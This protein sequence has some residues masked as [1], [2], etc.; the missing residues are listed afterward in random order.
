LQVAVRNVSGCVGMCRN[1]SQCVVR[2]KRPEATNLQLLDRTL[3][4]NHNVFIFRKSFT[5]AT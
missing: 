5:E 3:N 1:V 4:L 2:E